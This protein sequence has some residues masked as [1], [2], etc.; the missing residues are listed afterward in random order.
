MLHKIDSTEEEIGLCYILSTK[1][2]YFIRKLGW[3][4]LDMVLLSSPIKRDWFFV[5]RLNFDRKH[6]ISHNR[7]SVVY[8]WD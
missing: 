4:K 2:F 1:T 3:S 5:S 7:Y 8:F 6:F